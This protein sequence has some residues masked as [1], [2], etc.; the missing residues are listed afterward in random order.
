MKVAGEW[1]KDELGDYIQVPRD[2]EITGEKG[3]HYTGH[4]AKDEGQEFIE[5]P[6]KRKFIKRTIAAGGADPKFFG[7]QTADQWNAI[8]QTIQ[9]KIDAGEELTPYE[10]KV[11]KYMAEG[12]K[13][14]DASFSPEG[15]GTPGWWK[16]REEM[17]SEE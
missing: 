6:D 7:S 8:D 13:V 11:Q 2:Q 3:R 9:D 17:E 16:R 14:Y 1:E 10:Q 4:D 5:D 15:E 12:M